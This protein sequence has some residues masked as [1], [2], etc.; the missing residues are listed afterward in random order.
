MLLAAAMQLF[1]V[2]L[3]AGIGHPG[4]Q[5]LVDVGSLVD[6][7]ADQPLRLAGEQRFGEM[8][9]GLLDVAVAAR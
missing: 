5:Q 1:E 7:R 8:P 2:R 6:D 9:V 3:L 4:Q